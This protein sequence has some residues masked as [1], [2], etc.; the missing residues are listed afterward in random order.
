MS[1]FEVEN[2]DLGEKSVP[3]SNGEKQE[4]NSQRNA[5]NSLLTIFRWR[6]PKKG[7]SAQVSW[8]EK[9]NNPPM[10]AI[11]GR[12]EKHWSGRRGFLQIIL[13]R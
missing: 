8:Y 4:E 5:E 13:S 11:G 1:G 3:F 12:W 10:E 7:E 9:R 2:G 6:M